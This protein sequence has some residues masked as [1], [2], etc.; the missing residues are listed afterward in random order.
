MTQFLNQS[1]IFLIAPTGGIMQDKP[2]IVKV[3]CFGA[4]CEKDLRNFLCGIYKPET[5]IGW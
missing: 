2:E 3:I 5:Y 1:F 4:R